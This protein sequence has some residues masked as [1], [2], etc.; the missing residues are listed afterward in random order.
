MAN[1]I[2]EGPGKGSTGTTD[3]LS[4]ERDLERPR[5]GSWHRPAARRGYNV[6]TWDP[7]SKYASGGV[8]Q[9]NSPDFEAKDALR[10]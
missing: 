3:P 2:L 4:T 10:P 8:L 1:T 5:P 9:L 6:V 7:R